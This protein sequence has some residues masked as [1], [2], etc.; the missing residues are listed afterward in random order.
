MKHVE[1]SSFEE[2]QIFNLTEHQKANITGMSVS[3]LQKDR[4]RDRPRVPFRRYGAAIRY[5]AED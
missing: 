5:A 3:F 1:N 2:R 4:L